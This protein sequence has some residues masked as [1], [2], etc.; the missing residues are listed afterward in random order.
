[1]YCITL[2]NKCVKRFAK[3][4]FFLTLHDPEKGIVLVPWCNGSTADFG[5]ACPSSNLGGTAF[6]N[7]LKFQEVFLFV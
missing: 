4:V 5:S 7:L 1:M 6:K 2:Y 3:I